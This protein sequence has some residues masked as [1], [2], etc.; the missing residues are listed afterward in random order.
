MSP[1]NG[2]TAWQTLVLTELENNRKSVESLHTKVGEVKDSIDMRINCL[3]D[4]IKD[5]IDSMFKEEIVP[6]KTAIDGLKIKSGVWGAMAGAVPILL[7]IAIILIKHM[8]P[9]ARVIDD[10]IVSAVTL[11]K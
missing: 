10:N 5:D 3:K 1:I 11:S 7:V 9:E 8:F 6:M 4:E 2:L